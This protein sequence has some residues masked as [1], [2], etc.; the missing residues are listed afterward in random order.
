MIIL[1]EDRSV[2]ENLPSL[3]DLSLNENPL[4]TIPPFN[5]SKIRSLSLHDTLLTSAVF[6]SSYFASLLQTISLSDNEIRSINEDDFINLRNSKVNSLKIDSS[7]LSSIHPNAFNKLVQLQSLSLKNNQLKSCEFLPTLPLLAS[8]KLDGNQFTS[9]PQELSVRKN[10]KSVFFTNNFISV[11]DESSPLHTWMKMNYTDMKIYLANN[12]FDCCKSLWFIRFLNTSSKFIGDASL[13]KCAT[14]TEYAGKFLTK[15]N[16]D[17]MN[18]GGII[19]NKSWWTTAR[20]IG[21][22]VGGAV[23]LLILLIVIAVLNRRGRSLSEYTEIGGIDD[24]TPTAP[25]SSQSTGYQFPPYG[26]DNNNYDAI[27][28]YSTAITN[29][30]NGSQAPTHSTIDGAS[31]VDNNRI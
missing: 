27:S 26:E 17:Q 8:I 18:C 16:P 31:V 2:I 12:T 15:L 6:P 3:T 1:G 9:L 10:I 19:P 28:T 7:S 23:T 30:P 24:P 14:P 25:F 20:V 13:L 11:I 5:D 4:V 22:S 29:A 21:V